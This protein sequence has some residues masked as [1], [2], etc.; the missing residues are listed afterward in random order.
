MPELLDLLVMGDANPDLMLRGDV[1]PRF[2]QVEQ[3]LSDTTLTLGGSAAITAH[4]AAGLGLRVGLISVVGRDL[5]GDFTLSTLAAGGV[6]VSRVRRGDT[7]TGLSVILSRPE[8]RAILTYTGAIERLTAEQI[9]LADVA[10]A[11]HVHASSYYLQPGL[12]AA[13]PSVF[14]HARRNGVTTSLD[15]NADPA[16]AWGGVRS[17]LPF[18]DTLLPNRVEALG[19]AS[20]LAGKEIVD[21]ED[22]AETLARC[23]PLV[24][25]KDGAAGALAVGADCHLRVPAERADVVDTTGAG[26]TF[27]AAFIAA[28]L[29]GRSVDD[30]VHRAVRAA[31]RSTAYT[32]GIDPAV[33]SRE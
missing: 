32:G 31:S 20:T 26:D 16:G 9:D 19:I 22:A 10:G 5:F 18:V 4:V 28:R 6:D 24:V 14:A 12:I 27:N 7:P 2:G 15:T 25:V 23:G 33:P 11:R 1:V 3:L 13:L 21:V 30:S 17:L 8:T 29:A